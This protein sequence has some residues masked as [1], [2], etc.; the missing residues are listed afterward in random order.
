M[1]NATVSVGDNANINMT[2][3]ITTTSTRPIGKNSTLATTASPATTTYRTPITKPNIEEDTNSATIVAISVTFSIILSIMAVCL[4]IKFC[5]K[6]FDHVRARIKSGTRRPDFSSLYKKVTRSKGND[7]SNPGIP[8]HYKKKLFSHYEVPRWRLTVDKSQIVGIGHCG[9]V[10]RGRFI[11]VQGKKQAEK[12]GNSTEYQ[13]VA[14][15]DLRYKTDETLRAEF[16]KEMECA[17]KIGRHLNIVNLLGLIL[18]DELCMI[19]E[20]CALGSLDHCLRDNR[21]KMLGLSMNSD[22]AIASNT[23]K[24]LHGALFTLDD[25]VDFCF[26]ICRGM[27]YISSKGIIH[28]DLA[29]R[30]VL[31]DSELTAKICDFGMARD[32]SEYTLER[33]NVPLPLKWMA[34]EAIFDKR[35]TEKSDVWSFGVVIWEIFTMGE[36]PYAEIFRELDI[37]LLLKF[38]QTGSRLPRPEAIGDE[39]F[40]LMS[41]CWEWKA[42]ARPG[43]DIL[44]S[45]LEHM[46]SVD[47]RDYYVDCDM[48]NTA[49]NEEVIVKSLMDNAEFEAT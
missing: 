25:L 12:S 48:T 15:K 38:L 37:A 32:E 14:V 1:F 35:F 5:P 26:Q 43:F 16:F 36:N 40:G 6:K 31:L 17:V 47:K 18:K 19:M 29:T 28:R 10:Y 8:L 27:A 4:F 9:K 45:S 39:M 24:P 3:P 13:E 34:P 33:S 20:Y 41:S 7:Y 44:V 22:T 23:T 42:E 21:K 46:V 11:V 49:A 2:T 30:N